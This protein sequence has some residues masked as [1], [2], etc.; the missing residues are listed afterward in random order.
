MLTAFGKG[1]KWVEAPDEQKTELLGVAWRE[2]LVK[3]K[4]K[5]VLATKQNPFRIFQY[6]ERV[7]VDAGFLRV[8][9]GAENVGPIDS[10]KR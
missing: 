8:R 6:H 7:L 4:A 5:G 2:K 10:K 9:S 3:A 1:P